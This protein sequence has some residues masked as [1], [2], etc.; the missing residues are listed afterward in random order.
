MSKVRE[1]K[2][3]CPKCRHAGL[4][5]VYDSITLGQ[6]HRSIGDFKGGVTGLIDELFTYSCKS[7]GQHSD[8]DHDLLINDLDSDRMIQ[9]VNSM[10]DDE[11]NEVETHI[12]RVFG[13]AV[14]F[15][16]VKSPLDIIP[17]FGG[18]QEMMETKI[19]SL[20]KLI[21]YA[22]GLK[23]EIG[24]GYGLDRSDPIEVLEDYYGLVPELEQEIAHAVAVFYGM[25]RARTGEVEL[26]EDDGKMIDKIEVVFEGGDGVDKTRYIYFDITAAYRNIGKKID[27]VKSKK[28]IKAL[29]EGTYY[30]KVDPIPHFFAAAYYAFSLR[31]N[32]NLSPESVRQVLDLDNGDEAQNIYDKLIE[33]GF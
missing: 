18:A 5:T 2:V 31:K 6:G 24:S 23:L 1:V 8:V 33:C 17:L 28:Q 11:V 3:A 13:D 7:C 27:E 25:W 22:T 9:V 10:D 12:A 32:E 30:T 29:R 20:Q 14:Q 26:I 19:V 4:F 16:V 15:I 21:A